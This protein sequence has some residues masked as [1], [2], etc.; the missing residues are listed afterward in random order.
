M[1][2]DILGLILLFMLIAGILFIAFGQITVRKL[3]N[4]PET[5]DALGFDYVSGRDIIN[6]AIA[7]SWPVSWVRRLRTTKLSFFYADPDALQKYTTIFDRCLARTFYWIMTGSVLALLL[8]MLADSLGAF[9][10]VH[11]SG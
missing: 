10:P 2:T 3:R 5:R 9:G 8:L 11:S 6:V 1:K 7:L 4:N